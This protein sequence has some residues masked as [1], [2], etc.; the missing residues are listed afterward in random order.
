MREQTVDLSV[1]RFQVLEAGATADVVDEDD[2]IILTGG[3]DFTASSG[4]VEERV[5]DNFYEV[6]SRFGKA[7]GAGLWS[8]CLC[9]RCR[10]GV[11][12]GGAGLG[13]GCGR[14]LDS[15]FER[16]VRW[17]EGIEAPATERERGIV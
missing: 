8:V 4:V 1:Q 17:L 15:P 11:V 5:V 13:I 6:R 12:A 7:S 9:C 14:W 3:E 16:Y 10:R 2:G